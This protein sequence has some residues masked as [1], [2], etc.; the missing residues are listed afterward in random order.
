MPKS[1]DECIDE[2]TEAMESAR[3]SL[4]EKKDS[5][6]DNF[7]FTVWSSDEDIEVVEKLTAPSVRPPELAILESMGFRDSDLNEKLLKRM[8]GNLDHVVEKLLEIT[9]RKKVALAE[10]Q[11]TSQI[12]PKI[13]VASDHGSRICHLVQFSCSLSL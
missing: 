7:S 6:E 2:L 4:D 3:R 5:E 9:S 11:R 13:G 1:L 12:S 8:K 10:K